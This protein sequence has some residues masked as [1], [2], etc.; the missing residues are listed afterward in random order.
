[1]IH[2]PSLPMSCSA[3]IN[4]DTI[5]FASPELLVSSESGMQIGS[6]STQEADIYAF[7]MV[8]FQVRG[9]GYGYRPYYIYF[10]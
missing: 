2:D 7:G 8:I 3:Q 1:M 4:D 6:V 9:R 5:V 10:V